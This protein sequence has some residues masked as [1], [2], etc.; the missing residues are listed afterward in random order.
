MSPLIACSAHSFWGRYYLQCGLFFGL[1]L[2]DEAYAFRVC[3]SR[4]PGSPFRLNRTYTSTRKEFGRF[5]SFDDRRADGLSHNVSWI[6]ER[7]VECKRLLK[8]TGSIFL[9]CDP[10]RELAK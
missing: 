5:P 7:I 9:H 8:K 6:T 10:L 1:S 4:L 2:H 3:G